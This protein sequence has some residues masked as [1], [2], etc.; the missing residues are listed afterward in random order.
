MIPRCGTHDGGQA[1]A[2]QWYG[3]P[4]PFRLALP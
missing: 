2:P 1:Q 3:F 4:T